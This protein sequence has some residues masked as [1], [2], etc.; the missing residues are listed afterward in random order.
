MDYGDECFPEKDIDGCPSWPLVLIAL[1]NIHH[2]LKPGGGPLITVGRYFIDTAGEKLSFDTIK[3]CEPG[4]R[5]EG[6]L[7]FLPHTVARLGYEC[8]SFSHGTASF[9]TGELS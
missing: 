4:S 1:I 5:G 2:H 9:L 8:A 6:A 7:A 3:R